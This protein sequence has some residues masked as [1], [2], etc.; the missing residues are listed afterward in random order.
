MPNHIT[1]IV[2]F[3]CTDE[4]FQVIKERFCN[5]EEERVDFNKIVPMPKSLDVES[6]SR[7]EQ[8]YEV[9][10]KY[11]ALLDNHHPKLAA[12][13]LNDFLNKPDQWGNKHT[14]DDW[15]LGQAYYSNRKLYGCTTWYDWCRIYWGTKWNAY[16]C[17]IS[18]SNHSFEFL[19]AWSGVIELIYKMAK[20][21]PAIPITY[22]FCDE[23]IGN[24]VG[25]FVFHGD[26]I[27]D[28]SPDSDTKEAYEL[29][30]EVMGIDL[31]DWG[32]YLNEDGTNYEYRDEY[33]AIDIGDL[34]DLENAFG[35]GEE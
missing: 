28:Y 1:N 6:G 25:Y 23:D 14:V 18:D 21:F 30:E 20:T 8:A 2:E 27:D 15:N 24:N 31:S 3:H 35:N 4:Q 22:K 29:V 26:S 10:K 34:V 13:L 33:E 9:V 16:D 17:S 12:R 5:L 7:G 19:T 11:Y 32:Y